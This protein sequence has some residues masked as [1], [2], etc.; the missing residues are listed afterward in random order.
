MAR[1]TDYIKAFLISELL[2]FGYGYVYGTYGLYAIKIVSSQAVG[3]KNQIDGIKEKIKTIEAQ[4]NQWQAFP[5]YQEKLARQR[6]NMA[7]KGDEVYYVT[8]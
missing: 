8:E 2:L 3:L 1:Y 7:R 5:F 6:L 4:C